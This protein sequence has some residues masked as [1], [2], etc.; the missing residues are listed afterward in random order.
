M[1]KS[2]G[3]SSSFAAAVE[4]VSSSGGNLMPPIMGAVAFLMPEFIPGITYFDVIKA[5]IIPGIMYYFLVGLSVYFHS[6]RKGIG[7][8]TGEM[9]VS[10]KEI[11]RDW[12]GLIISVAVLSILIYLLYKRWPEGVC[13][14]AA[15]L[16]GVG[17]HLLIGGPANLGALKKRFVDIVKGFVAG[18]RVLCWLY[19]LLASLQ[20][21]IFVLAKTGLG[22]TVSEVVLSI[23]G[24]G[25]NLLPAL[26]VT[27]IACIIMGMGVTMT[28]AY[29]IVVAV[30]ATPLTKVVGT[31]LV[32]HMFIFYM[33]M[34][35]NITPPVCT[36]VYPAAAL[37]KT[38]WIP[39]AAY[40][41]LLGLVAF[42]APYMFVYGPQLITIG[43]PGAIIRAVITGLIGIVFLSSGIW[44]QLTRRTL[45][46]ERILMGVGGFLL[47]F[48]GYGDFFGLT[49]IAVSLVVY[50]IVNRVFGQTAEDNLKP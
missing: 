1:M 9:V 4:A 29:I 45:W 41:C 18:G 43:S 47:M 5:A 26:I 12:S 3:F 30:L 23:A 13:G 33:C 38:P 50:F 7:K 32:A 34:L 44:G 37:A 16:T 21:V 10:G 17:L 39:V 19:L 25:E 49:T 6:K 48:P 46:F 14:T 22:F 2:T 15:L 27:M 20:I 8:L 24:G 28:A 42:V 35:A 11:L 36:V 31:P 40:A